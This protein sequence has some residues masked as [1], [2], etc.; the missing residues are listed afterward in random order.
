MSFS[1]YIVYVDEAGDHSLASIDTDFPVFVLAFCIFEKQQYINQTTPA[2][3]EFK[4]NYF[5]HD[6][7]ILHEREIRKSIAPF[8]ILQNR[9]VRQHFMADL[10][11]LMSEAPFTLVASCIDKQNFIH[12]RGRNENPYHVAMQFGLERV[13]YFLQERRQV[14]QKTHIVFE[15][16]GKKEDNELELEFRRL[17]DQSNINGMSESL[18]I[19]FADK[20][21][22]STGLQLADMVARPIGRHIMES[23]QP[24]RA[25]EIIKTKFRTSPQGNIRGWG[26]KCYP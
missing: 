23:T 4:F 21:V 20:K 7:T 5:G 9:N 12:R 3:Q 24:N 19:I 18:D 8:N 1:E 25:F 26:L 14:N 13:F 2:V 10:S 16:R 6:M 15:R 11:R 22:N 17:L